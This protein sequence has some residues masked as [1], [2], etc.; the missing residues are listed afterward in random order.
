MEEIEAIWRIYERSVMDSD[1]DR[2][3]AL[4]EGDGVQLP[5]DA[6]ALHGGAEIRSVIGPW[7]ARNRATMKK[8]VAVITSEETQAVGDLAF[9]SGSYTFRME[10][11]SGGPP[12]I[13][14]GKF[15][16]VFRRQADGSWKIRRDCFNS[17]VPR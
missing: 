2:W 8:I 14:D 7:M 15:L 3:M 9:S 10:P 5:P 13:T 6:P 11:K 12:D 16:T 17:N 1:I 4:W